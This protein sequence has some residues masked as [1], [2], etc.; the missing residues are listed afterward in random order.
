MPLPNL[1]PAVDG[2]NGY[3][4]ECPIE[5][6][7][8]ATARPHRRVRCKLVPGGVIVAEPEYWL[9]GP[10]AGVPRLLQPVAHSLLQARED[11]E[12]AASALTLEQLWIRPGGAASCGFHLKHLAGAL[13][14]LF[15]Y[16]RGRALTPD[17]LAYLKAET[18]P[19]DP[20]ADPSAVVSLVNVAIDRA[21]DQVRNTTEET[22][23]KECRVGRQAVP[24]TVLGLLFHAAEHTTRHA[25]Q[26]ITTSKIVRAHTGHA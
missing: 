2:R 7:T 9:R 21:L 20:S 23:A 22:L 1:P 4:I 3:P 12:A 25:G 11:V 10:V 8:P 6:G 17:Q 13:D 19:G 26:A 18:E 24:A 5:I 14:R 16:A 15:T